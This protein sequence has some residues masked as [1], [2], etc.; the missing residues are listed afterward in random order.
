MVQKIEQNIVETNI[1]ERGLE[2]L[3]A[4]M[5]GEGKSERRRM[6]DRGRWFRSQAARAVV[7]PLELVSLRSWVSHTLVGWYWVGITLRKQY[8]FR[9]W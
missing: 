2:T 4:L 8:W 6:F 3:E 9:S 1:P 5:S 7:L